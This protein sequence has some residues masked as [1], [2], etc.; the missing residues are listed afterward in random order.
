MPLL[1][2]AMPLVTTPPAVIRLQLMMLHTAPLAAIR[3]QLM[4][5]HTTVRTPAAIRMKPAMPLF[6]I[7]M[8]LHAPTTPC[9]RHQDAAQPRSP[10][11]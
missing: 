4:M 6:I 10:L 8:M 5:L 7:I 2:P 1:T 9:P 11:P 3:M